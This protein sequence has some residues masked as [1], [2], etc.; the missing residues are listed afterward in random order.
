M[1]KHNDKQEEELNFGSSCCRC[2]CYQAPDSVICS[3]S[4]I[5]KYGADMIIGIKWVCCLQ[6][7]CAPK[8]QRHLHWRRSHEVSELHTCPFT[9]ASLRGAAKEVC[10]PIVGEFQGAM[11]LQS[12]MQFL[13]YFTYQHF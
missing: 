12:I 5:I 13:F 7:N 1:M 11:R 4:N 6:F 2:F 3:L 10:K 8:A 9:F